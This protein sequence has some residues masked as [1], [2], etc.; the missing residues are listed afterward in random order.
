MDNK[1]LIAVKREEPLF[2]S[3]IDNKNN[4]QFVSD[5]NRGI[6]F[7]N[8]F[9]TKIAIERGEVFKVRFQQGYGSEIRGQHFVVA[10]QTSRE[11]NQMITI[12]PL[13]SLK[14]SREYNSKSTI[15]L[16]E[17]PEIPNCKESVALVNQIR[18]IDKMRLFGDKALAN[19]VN[20]ACNHIEDFTGEYEV[21]LKQIYRLTKEQ[22]D[23]ILHAVNNYLFVGSVERR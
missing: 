7:N 3:Y 16:G 21:Q 11:N 5:I 14:E 18:T 4:N 17:I 20:D 13:S 2:S 19:F 6:F 10:M 22:Y 12:V 23:K 9:T 8:H 1:K 15:R